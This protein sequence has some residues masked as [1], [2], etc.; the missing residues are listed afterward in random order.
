MK[1]SPKIPE[2]LWPVFINS[3]KDSE[4]FSDTAYQDSRGYWTIGYGHRLGDRKPEPGE[5]SKKYLETLLRLDL[6]EA[7]RHAKSLVRRKNLALSDIRFTVLVEMVF[8]LGYTGVSKFLQFFITLQLKDWVAA[9][10]EMR[11]TAAGETS[12][13]YKEEPERVNKLCNRLLTDNF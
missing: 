6:H 3:V 2:D 4:G 11:H 12:P 7:E 1:D 10:F 9:C 8:I 5:Y 13:W